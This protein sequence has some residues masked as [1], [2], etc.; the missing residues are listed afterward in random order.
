MYEW[1]KEPI[2]QS[3]NQST[4]Q[5]IYKVRQQMA[6]KNSLFPLYKV[7]HLKFFNRSSLLS[8][9]LWLIPLKLGRFCYNMA[10][11]ISISR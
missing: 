7:C 5:L 4:D 2:N 1:M 11:F 8:N 3:T 10:F 9:V 6:F